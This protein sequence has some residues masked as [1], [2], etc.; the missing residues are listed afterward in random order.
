MMLLN[1]NFKLVFFRLLMIKATA[2]PR[3]EI[4][5]AGMKKICTDPIRTL[6]FQDYSTFYLHLLYMKLRRSRCVIYC[7]FCF[8]Y[9]RVYDLN[10][11]IFLMV[12]I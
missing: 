4:E 8:Y 12:Q 11:E 1:E 3:E 7:L 2:L 9:W 10:S 5:E 6:E